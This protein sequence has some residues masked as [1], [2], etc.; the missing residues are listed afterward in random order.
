MSRPEATR[1]TRRQL[2]KTATAAGIGAVGF[3]TIVPASALGRD[4]KVAPSNRITVGIIG[5]GNQGLND[6]KSFLKDER[7]QI[8]AVCDV[9]K[10]GPG[11]WNGGVAGREPAKRLIEAHYAQQKEAGTYKGCDT[12]TDFREVIGRKDIDA[13]E[14][15]LPDHWHA[16]PVIL[17]AK[18]KKDIYCQKPLSLSI[19]EGRAMADAVKK[20]GVIF[21][22]GSQQRS[23]S[24]FRR[25]CELVRNGRIG[26]VH[27]VRCGLPGGRP[28]FG[29]TGDRKAPEK[30]PD[31]FD[32]EMWL[33]PA[34]EAP[35]VPARCHV[36]FRWIYDY[37]GGQV[38]D[39]GGHHPDCAQWGLG[40]DYTGPVEIRGAKAEFPVDPL[41]NTATEYYFEAIY[42]DGVKLIISSK[43]KGGVTWEGTEGKVWANRGQHDADPK[44]I[45]DSQIGPN[46]V[47][48]YESKDH[49]RNFIDCVISRKETVA[50][51]EVAHRSITICHL[52]NIA[53]R[54]GR[55][56]LKWD[57]EKEQILGDTDAS[58]MLTRPYRAPWK[59]DV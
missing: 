58:R 49:F 17:A 54:L 50:P 3:P 12:L 19:G 7:V 46:E 31:G 51:V 15:C 32:Y 6:I 11:Y 37:S 2:L 26:K 45:L 43:E 1:I 5:T 10:E 57:P 18:A 41:W 52:G 22:T 38:T 30:V 40:T 42:K 39:W 27:T 34:P 48:L 47:H 35:Y 20:Y 4:G 13:V 36:N 25:A 23:D 24:N 28:D 14:V 33:G 8:I 55:E 29:K 16:I 9:N 21:Q 59:L 56:S 53:M 44:S